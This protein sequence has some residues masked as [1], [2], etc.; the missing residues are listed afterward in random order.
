MKGKRKA[1][2]KGR[3]E[4]G[5]FEKG[6]KKFEKKWLSDKVVPTSYDHDDLEHMD[7]RPKGG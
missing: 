2:T 5:E 6:C 1:V 3:K 7:G 4:S